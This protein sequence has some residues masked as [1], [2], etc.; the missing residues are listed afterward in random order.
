[1]KRCQWI[2]NHKPWTPAEEDFLRENRGTMSAKALAAAL[3]GRTQ[4]AVQ[5]RCSQLGILKRD[6]AV[7]KMPAEKRPRYWWTMP[8]IAILHAHAHL[9]P[10]AIKSLYLPHRSVHAIGAK[11]SFLGIRPQAMRR[12][13]EVRVPELGLQVAA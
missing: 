6:L 3:P 9:Q 8:E 2:H 7:R 11:I 1:M 4:Q 10:H 5:S 12:L 13:P